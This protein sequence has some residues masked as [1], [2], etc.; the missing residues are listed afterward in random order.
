MERGEEREEEERADRGVSTAD[1]WTWQGGRVMEEEAKCLV[2]VLSASRRRTCA[3]AY[4]LF[5]KKKRVSVKKKSFSQKKEFQSK[6]V[7]VEGS[8][9]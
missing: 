3:A 4:P 9:P 2:C 6:R 7:S 8:Q 1:S 5:P